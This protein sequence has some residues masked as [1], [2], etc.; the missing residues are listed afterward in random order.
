MEMAIWAGTEVIAEYIYI[1]YRAAH[2][3]YGY[4]ARD[5]HFF[6]YQ[7]GNWEMKLVECSYDDWCL[8]L[9]RRLLR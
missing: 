7:P 4:G 5:C 2:G 6:V 3:V 8:A 9:T 1:R